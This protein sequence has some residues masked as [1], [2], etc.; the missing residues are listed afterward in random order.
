[1]IG[2]SC[3]IEDNVWVAPNAGV[4]QK[5]TIGQGA[6]VGLGAVVLKNVPPGETWAGVPAK[7]L[8]QNKPEQQT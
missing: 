6:M 2:G 1:M 4:L 7:K 8:D 5:S 3:V